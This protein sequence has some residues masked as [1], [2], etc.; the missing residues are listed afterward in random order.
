MPPAIVAVAPANGATGVP[1]NARIRVLVSEP[2]DAAAVT[3][4]TVQ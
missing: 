1:V 2:I 4:S 3:S